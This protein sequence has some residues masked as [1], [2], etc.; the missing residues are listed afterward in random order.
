MFTGAQIKSLGKRFRDGNYGENDIVLLEDYRATFDETLLTV[1]ARINHALIAQKVPFVVAGRTKRIRSIIRKLA[2]PQNHDMDLS[3]MADIVGLRVLV[4][5]IL[6][7]E[8]AVAAI[9]KEF[10]DAKVIDYRNTDQIYRSIHILVRVDAGFRK[11]EIQIRTLPQ[12]L[13]ANESESFGEEVKAGGGDPDI[14]AYLKELSSDCNSLD[15]GIPKT[16]Q[17]ADS[18][19]F[20]TRLPIGLRLMVLES[21]FKRIVP[22]TGEMLPHE[23]YL[24]VYDNETNQC[25]QKYRYMPEERM[26]ALDDFRRITRSLDENRYEVLVLNSSSDAVIQVTHPRFFPEPNLE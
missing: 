7:Q 19:Y 20:K 5:N 18:I 10:P 14:Q 26:E 23:S 15:R 17:D 8:A 4:Q 21:L 13:W 12:Q 11:M 16:D 6:V 1:T 9:T 22:I 25:L 3:R 2:R 24:V